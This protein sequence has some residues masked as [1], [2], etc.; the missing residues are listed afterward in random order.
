MAKRIAI[1][2][3]GP[4]GLEA[5]LYAKS[6]GHDV[7]VFERG[8]VAANVGEWKFVRLFSPWLLSTTSLGRNAISGIAPLLPL[9]QYPTGRDFRE[10]YLLPL[11]RCPL[12]VGCV[13]ENNPVT[14]VAKDSQGD[15]PFRIGAKD[16]AGRE[17]VERADILL[18]CSG[19]YGSHRWAGDHGNP[20]PGEP[21]LRDRIFYA[22]PDVLGQHRDRFADHHALVIGCTYSS[23][24]VLRDLQDLAANRRR[25]M[26]TWAVRRPDQAVH[27]ILNDPLRSRGRLVELLLRLIEHPP[28]W[29]QF[30]STAVLQSITATNQHFTATFRSNGRIVSLMP[31]EV[32]SLNGFRPDNSMYESATTPAG[33]IKA[34]AF[35]REDKAPPTFATGGSGSDSGFFVLGAKSYGMNSNF[36]LQAG[37][38]QVCEIFT[39][40][41]ANENLD[42]YQ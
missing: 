38:M 28:G 12:L 5:A 29:L 22:I 39:V 1:I 37:H 16:E 35:D 25:T 21:E 6:L 3:A 34:A 11:S 40:I 31:D 33:P 23:A 30:L 8:C 18:D 26:V 24:I 15:L 2:G 41:E 17:Y 32:V 36:L 14:S 10:R 13:R 27:P 9:E 19:T 7:V 4:I 42:L 20:A